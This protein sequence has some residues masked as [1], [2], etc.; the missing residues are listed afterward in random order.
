MIPKSIRLVLMALVAAA[1]LFGILQVRSC[2]QNKQ[3][4]AEAKVERKQN[5][6]TLESAKDSIATQGEAQKREQA[7]AELGA[8]NE[9]EIQNAEGA[10]IPIPAAVNAARM[11]A[12]CKREANRDRDSCRVFRTPAP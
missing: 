8:A 9:K 6:A 4:V 5:K 1:L 12:V 3:R 7:A 11:R 2:Q 10:D